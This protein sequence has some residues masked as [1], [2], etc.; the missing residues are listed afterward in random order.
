MEASVRTI[1]AR[2]GSAFGHLAARGTRIAGLVHA[3][4]SR[5]WVQVVI[6]LE[7]EDQDPALLIR[8]IN[9]GTTPVTLR[10]FAL[11]GPAPDSVEMK[12]LGPPPS[13]NAPLNAAGGTFEHRVDPRTLAD[14]LAHKGYV[15]RQPIRA[16]FWGRG[17]RPYRS[18]TF[19]FDLDRWYIAERVKPPRRIRPVQAKWEHEAAAD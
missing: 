11:R 17:G 16:T 2:G 12:W 6:V 19:S 13:F 9:R 8:A 1:A 5:R 3:A 18:R 7:S 10:R 14:V 4:A 15:G